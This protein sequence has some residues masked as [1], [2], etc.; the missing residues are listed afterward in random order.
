MNIL[1]A[2]IAC[3]SYTAIVA[4]VYTFAWGLS[5]HLF[6]K[7]KI[8][9]ELV[10]G[11]ILGVISIFGVIILSLTMGENK[12]YMLLILLPI[13]LYWTCLIFISIYA[14]IGVV[15]WNLLGLFLFPTLFPQYFISFLNTSSIILIITSYLMA[16]VIYIINIFYKKL[17]TWV[18]WSIITITSLIVGIVLAFPNIKSDGT[19]DYLITI[20]LWLGTGYITYAYFAIINQ[21]YNHALK[22][23]NLVTYDY[24]YYLNQASAHDE[25]LN[26]I[27][28][29][30]IRFG[31]YFT[32]FISN[33]D[34]F[35]EKVNNEIRETVVTSIAKQAHEIFTKNYN[36]VIFF[37]P[38]Y[39]TFG[40]FIPMLEMQ[41]S[42]KEEQRLKFAEKISRSISKIQTTFKIENFKVS[43]KVRGVVSYYGFHSNSLE[44][45]FEYNV[46]TQNNAAFSDREKV[47]LVDPRKVLKEKTKYKKILTLNEL[48]SLNNSAPIFES[49]YSIEKNDYES[50]YLNS[51]V[52]GI[53][54][55]SNLFKE[56]L[57]TIKEYGLNSIFIRYLALNALKSIAK[58]KSYKKRNFIE[59]DPLFISSESFSVDSF[60]LKLKSLKID[61]KK[62]VFNFPI[63]QE[64]EN[65]DLLEKNINELRENGVSFSVSDLGSEATDFGLLGIYRPN[66]VFLERSIV[67]KINLIK[68]N[69]K[70]IKNIINIC[71]KINAKLVATD[72][73]TYMIYKSLKELGIKY[74]EG[75]LI[76]HGI[77]PK[78]ELENELKYLLVK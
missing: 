60:I 4:I 78:M 49:I 76:G 65:R 56:K 21:I 63:T 51:A 71:N 8:Y 20:L 46:I 11:V 5:R 25:I 29:N 17:T 47:V 32:F 13:F 45:L 61:L 18:I 72:V 19:V 37:K 35:D 74:F 39:K 43:I 14:T 64:V 55:T 28:K 6:E 33:Y 3:L 69:E 66:Y 54:I 30:K 75:N 59:Y 68:E 34:K 50:F 22:L 26:Y 23:R 73:D 1:L 2:A 9:Y 15:V 7:I 44:T 57:E 12:N 53:E 58:Y 67:K 42:V 16:F 48:V 27:H 24:Q 77:E 38:N 10:L 41:N 36:Q 52:E 62:L 31:T 40:I 70:I